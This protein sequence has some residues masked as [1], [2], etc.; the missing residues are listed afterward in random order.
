MMQAKLAIIHS[1]SPADV[2]Y[3]AMMM[4]QLCHNDVVEVDAAVEVDIN[5]V[6]SRTK[7]FQE[8]EDDAIQITMQSKPRRPKLK[9]ER[10]WI[11]AQD[12]PHRKNKSSSPN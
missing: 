1:S 4:I 9:L 11:E 10:M 8:K 6:I 3:I 5:V 2:V 7:F 12:L